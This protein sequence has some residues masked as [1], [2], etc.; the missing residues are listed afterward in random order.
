[1]TGCRPKSCKLCVLAACLLAVWAAA[2][3]ATDP[4]QV[5]TGESHTW[6]HAVGKLEVPGQR[7]RD[8]RQSHYVEDCSATLVARAG[9]SHANTVIT[10]WHCLE[11]Y[12]D[13]SRPITFTVLTVSGE[14][15]QREAYR[16]QDGG[17]MHADWAILRLRQAVTR[18]QAPSLRVHER[19]ADPALPVT[20]AGF[21]GDDGIGN[22]GDALTFDSGCA[23][24]R[25]DSALGDTDCTA[26]KGASGGAVVQLSDTGEARVC[27]V[28]SQGNG[29]GR[30]T[31][32]PVSTFRNALNRH[33]D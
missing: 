5:F 12:G 11:W 21:S 26:F 32:V 1:M 28:I 14:P 31:F 13:L 8:G 29:E 27:G 22:S 15:L 16:L 20:M 33:L 25:Q 4:R 17:G 18:E 19:V 3:G 24:T 7:Y 2:A 30:S 23:I 9:R 6:L 10:A